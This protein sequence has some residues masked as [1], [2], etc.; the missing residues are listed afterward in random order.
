[1]SVHLAHP[2]RGR[3]CLN[4]HEGTSH[5][6]PAAAALTGRAQAL[7]RRLAVIEFTRTFMVWKRGHVPGRDPSGE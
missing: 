1:M 7:L 6:R 4:G 3:H 5:Y 2:S